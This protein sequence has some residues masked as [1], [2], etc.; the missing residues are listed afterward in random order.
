MESEQAY[1]I[2]GIHASEKYGLLMP[3]QVRHYTTGEKLSPHRGSSTDFREYRAYYPGDDIRTL[4]WRVYA[5]SDTL[6][7]KT[8]HEDIIPHIEII[9][10]VTASMA[11]PGTE[12]KRAAMNLCALIA[13]AAEREGYSYALW[14]AGDGFHPAPRG[15]HTPRVWSAPSFAHQHS[16]GD[17]WEILPPRWQKRTMR[18]VISDLLWSSSPHTFMKN[19]SREAA[20]V[21]ILQLLAQEE[22]SPE[23]RGNVTLKNIET[24][25]HTDAYID[26]SVAERY[27]AALERHCDLWRAAC[28]ECGAVLCMLSA[29]NI[30][31]RRDMTVL[32]QS[33]LLFRK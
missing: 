24:A 16:P 6:V 31:D 12:K 19:I 20:A 7:V 17:A 2:E 13:T 22:W 33:G 4:D 26:E 9:L 29:E 15:R 8:F 11:L 10:D 27:R 23:M 25:E 5:R 21:Y 32:E 1:F 30:V 18:V 3:Q 14:Y 28:R